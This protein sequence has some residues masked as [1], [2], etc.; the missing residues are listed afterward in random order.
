MDF[1]PP[2]LPTPFYTVLIGLEMSRVVELNK[3]YGNPVTSC[4][5]R[6]CWSW[7]CLF[8]FTPKARVD[9]A[10]RRAE[11]GEGQDSKISEIPLIPKNV[12]KKELRSVF[13]HGF[14]VHLFG[15]R[16]RDTGGI[17]RR[18]SV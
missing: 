14:S 10:A 11:C 4:D 5:C 8:H 15:G 7:R 3:G 2:L 1:F 17:I 9:K 18:Y 16:T 12:C 6:P 13:C